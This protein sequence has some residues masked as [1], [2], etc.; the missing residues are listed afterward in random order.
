VLVKEFD[1][2]LPP[3]LIAQEPKDRR[4]ESRL[5]ILSKETGAIKEGIFRDIINYL[6]TGDVLVLNQTRVIPAR[7]YGQTNDKKVELLLL[8][9]LQDQI[10]EVLSKPARK[11]KPGV[12]VKF[13]GAE[14]K[15]LERKPTGIRVV[16]FVGK[17]VPELLKEI[18]EIPLP[19]YIKKPLQEIS[20]YQTVYAQ[21]NGSIAAP[22]AGL[23][24]TQE[25]LTKLAQRGIEILK[26][27]LHAG[28]GTFRPVKTT[29]VEEHKVP[30]EEFEITEEVALRINHAK[31]EGRRIVATGTTVVRALESQAKAKKGK[32]WQLRPV[33]GMTDLFIYPGYEFKI[34]D[35][36]IT[37]FHLPK[38]S[39]LM[40]VCAFCPKEYVMRAY[41]YAIR[42]KF[43]FYSLGDAMF[44]Y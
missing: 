13:E 7:I 9:P 12:I 29:I 17:P 34:V 18:G 1:Y 37:N 3:E 40:L 42:N 20:R 8:R 30:G 44:I 26:I 6:K 43:R 36:L 16:E 41:D 23:H 35:A 32:V 10:W 33:Q 39:L 11:L 21:K 25:L 31:I 27:T 4:D 15:V 2:Y 24:F 14:A 19:P 5:L 28:L 22:T 38:S